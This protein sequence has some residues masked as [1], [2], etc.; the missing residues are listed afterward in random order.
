MSNINIT[1]DSTGWG[2]LAVAL[3]IGARGEPLI[4]PL[5]S[6]EAPRMAET[7]SNPPLIP[8]R[9]LLTVLY[10]MMDASCMAARENTPLTTLTLKRGLSKRSLG[11]AWV[12]ASA[13]PPLNTN[14]N[15]TTETMQL[16]ATVYTRSAVSQYMATAEAMDASPV[17]LSSPSISTA[18]LQTMTPIP[19]RSE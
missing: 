15:N 14:R 8:A 7:L 1:P 10:A 2:A 19:A 12:G 13:C 4:I 5:T 18:T 17:F 11:A 16:T 6:P 3:M 9:S